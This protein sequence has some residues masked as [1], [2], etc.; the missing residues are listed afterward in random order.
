LR[1]LSKKVFAQVARISLS[2][3]SCP[4]ELVATVPFKNKSRIANV[5]N[6]D[7]ARVMNDPDEISAANKR[8]AA[9]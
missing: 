4:E 6:N 5:E 9:V 2:Y 8:V 3:P 7:E 1:E